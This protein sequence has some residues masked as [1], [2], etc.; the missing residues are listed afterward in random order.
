MTKHREAMDL[1]KRLEELEYRV[2]QKLRDVTGS[3]AR[4]HH[5]EAERIRSQSQAVRAKAAETDEVSWDTVKH[6]LE[7]DWDIL[8]HSFERWVKEVDQ[9]YQEKS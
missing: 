3:L 7:A 2:G 1:V 5:E 9:A 4:H 6:D 8:N